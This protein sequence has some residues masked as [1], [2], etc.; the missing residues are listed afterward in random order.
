M[1]DFVAAWTKVMNADR[2]ASW[3]ASRQRVRLQ[4][5]RAG[6]PRRSRRKLLEVVIRA[7]R[8]KDSI[9]A[10][11]PCVYSLDEIVETR[12]LPCSPRPPDSGAKKMTH[13]VVVGAT[14]ALTSGKRTL[15]RCESA[16]IVLQATT[17]ELVNLFAYPTN[18]VREVAVLGASPAG[19]LSARSS[20][21]DA[22]RRADMV[23]LGYGLTKPSGSAGKHHEAQVV[24][25]KETLLA[26]KS[27]VFQV[28]DG[29]R[30]PSRWQRWTSRAY[31]GTPFLIALGQSFESPRK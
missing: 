25:L 7:T 8:V 31:P 3:Q 27:S 21:T 17:C 2:F 5:A 4:V 18:N 22:L 9:G 19:W 6:S 28:G 12:P 14:P 24:W 23:I 10:G 30:H 26:G 15:A 20:I 1:H 29:P 16:R 13:L 11:Y